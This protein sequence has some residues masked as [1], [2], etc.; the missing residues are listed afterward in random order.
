VIYPSKGGTPNLQEFLEQQFSDN[1]GRFFKDYAAFETAMQ[2][3]VSRCN[4]CNCCY[5]KSTTPPC[6]CR[7]EQTIKTNNPCLPQSIPPLSL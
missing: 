6:E 5:F 4:T 1:F 3:E 2:K 7:F